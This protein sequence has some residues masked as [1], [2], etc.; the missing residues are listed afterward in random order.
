MDLKAEF[1]QQERDRV[2]RGSEKKKDKGKEKDKG[3]DK[4]QEK[5]EAGAGIGG[6]AGLGRKKSTMMLG[7]LSK[8]L[9]R[10]GSVMRKTETGGGPT[11]DPTVAPGKSSNRRPSDSPSSASAPGSVST[12]KGKLGVLGDSPSSLYLTNHH[13]PLNGSGSLRSISASVQGSLRDRGAPSERMGS[14]REDEVDDASVQSFAQGE[15][16]VRAPSASASALSHNHK[17]MGS[18][19][20]VMSLLRPKMSGE[21]QRGQAQGLGQ[22]LG[23]GKNRRGEDE[24]DAGITMPL[25]TKVSSPPRN[26]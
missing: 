5:Q 3:K 8:G 13:L 9:S 21:Q 19:G 17:R 12:P 16:P 18:Q 26:V 24:G 2:A 4:V 7:G 25:A 23:Q 14:V 20:S 22:E 11:S 15:T 10:M 1:D 6:A